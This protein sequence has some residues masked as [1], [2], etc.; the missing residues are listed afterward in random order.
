MYKY[1]DT[2]KKYYMANR[3]KLIEKAKERYRKKKEN[4]EQYEN[5]LCRNK[6]LYQQKHYSKE[7]T[8]EEEEAFF[9][10]IR[11]DIASTREQDKNRIE[12]PISY[13]KLHE[14]FFSHLDNK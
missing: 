1:A 7:K 13:E 6:Y 12:E 3:E 2:H 8:P 4:P 10:K 11:N 14:L 5:L 9:N